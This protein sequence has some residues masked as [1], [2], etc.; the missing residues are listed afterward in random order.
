MF[1][2]I[3]LTPPFISS[4][5]NVSESQSSLYMSVLWKL[6]TSTMLQIFI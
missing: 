1:S 2:V 6:S 3:L 4:M 5:G